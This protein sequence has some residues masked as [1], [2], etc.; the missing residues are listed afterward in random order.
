MEDIKIQPPRLADLAGPPEVGKDYVVPCV[1]HDYCDDHIIPVTGVPHLEDSGKTFGQAA[2]IH[3]DLRFLSDANYSKIVADAKEH[4]VKVTG[5]LGVEVSIHPLE[6]VFFFPIGATLHDIVRRCHREQE[7]EFG[8]EAFHG[9]G[10]FYKPALN[11]LEPH[12]KDR[13]MDVEIKRCPHHGTHLS[14]MR[15]RSSKDGRA[16]VTCPNHGLTWDL[17]TGEM[18]SHERM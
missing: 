7:F 5:Q 17:K 10:S 6:T 4:S 12:F 11:I 8:Y 16:C 15:C 2:H 13:R 14:N 1:F 9:N 18:V 3:P